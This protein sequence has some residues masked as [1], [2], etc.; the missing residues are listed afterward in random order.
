MDIQVGQFCLCSN[1]TLGLAFKV[2]PIKLISYLAYM[3]NIEH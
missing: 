3:V 1:I 2:I